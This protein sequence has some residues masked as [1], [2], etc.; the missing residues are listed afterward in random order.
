MDVGTSAQATRRGKPTYPPRAQ[1]RGIEGH[2]VVQF[3]IRPDGSVDPGSVE[4]LEAN[5]PRVFERAAR[6]S[7]VEW[8][9][10]QADQRR[11]ARQR[12]EFNLR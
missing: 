12:F 9:F 10:Q 7:I 2:V 1:R 3:I 11:R 4:V 8:Q 5:P 6:Q